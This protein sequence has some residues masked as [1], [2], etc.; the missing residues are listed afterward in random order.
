[1]RNYMEFKN[2]A[3]ER[4]DKDFVLDFAPRCYDVSTDLDSFLLRME[5]FHKS[6]KEHQTIKALREQMIHIQN[7]KIQ[8]LEASIDLDNLL[9]LEEYEGVGQLKDK[10]NSLSIEHTRF[11]NQWKDEKDRELHIQIER[12]IS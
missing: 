9:I 8:L 3:L 4:Y 10:I 6:R 1:M 7:L 5:T 11:L 12:L 2:V